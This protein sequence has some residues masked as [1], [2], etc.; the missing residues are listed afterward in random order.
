MKAPRKPLEGMRTITFAD[1]DL[2]LNAFKLFS[3]HLIIWT[4]LRSKWQWV[5]KVHLGLER[6]WKHAEITKVAKVQN[7]GGYRIAQMQK[8]PLEDSKLKSEIYIAELYKTTGYLACQLIRKPILAVFSGRDNKL[9]KAGWNLPIWV[10]RL[11][12]VALNRSLLKSRQP[13]PCVHI[14]PWY[15]KSSVKRSWVLSGAGV[16]N[17]K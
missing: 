16:A 17:F 7:D 12:P 8:V 15:F 10:I 4:S 13:Y 2:S 5:V 1:D 14:L 3:E 6:L 9:F 11:R